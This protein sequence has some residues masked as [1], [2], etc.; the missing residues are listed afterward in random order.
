M[1]KS[2]LVHILKT[3]SAKDIRDMRKWLHSPAHNQRQDVI[4]LFNYFF[5][6]NHL[7]KEAY[8]EKPTIFSWI[9]PKETYN[10]AKMRQVIFFLLKAIEEFLIYQE[11]CTDEVNMKIILARVFR[12]RKLDKLFQKNI[13]HS[14]KLLESIDFE[15]IKYLRHN[16]LIQSEKSTFLSQIN[17]LDKNLQNVSNAL[18]ISFLS[19]KL[20]ES[21]LMLSHQSVYKK[22]LN[23]GLLDS[24]LP[25]VEQEEYLKHP[26]IATYFYVYK[27]IIGDEN[28]SYFHLLKE[29]ISQYES[30]FSFMEFRDILLMTI[31]YCI[32]KMN[33]GIQSFIREAFELF[34]LGFE[35]KILIEN[36]QV[37]RVTFHNVVSIGLKLKEYEWVENFINQYQQYLEETHRQG[38]VFYC[39]ARLHY[40]K[41]DYDKA[42]KLLVQEVDY[43]D[44]IINLSAKTL[45]AKMYYEQ[46]E[47]DV[48]ESLLESM[49]TYL[50][51]KKVMGYH[52]NNY[53]N[54]VRF[55]KK[56]LKATP[57][58]KNKREKLK[59]EITEA[60]PLTEKAWLLTQLSKI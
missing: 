8:L 22:E 21:C 6:D 4:Q 37:T 23:Y 24:L 55:T 26:I 56:L 31:N 33:S 47:F 59:L 46:D 10:D 15:N 34:K 28:E 38:F 50:Q 44:I 48:L 17:R 53:K 43:D 39:L 42:M 49:R 27:T 58:S 36:N 45:L 16:Y 32:R 18:D 13:K 1:K 11:V 30:Q 52:K 51:R 3:F 20:R 7:E 60:T 25:N 57:Y 35:K 9:F 12:Q 14:E 29:K 41:K 40:G 54:I 2:Q 19:E 5:E